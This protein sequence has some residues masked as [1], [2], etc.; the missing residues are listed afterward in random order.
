MASQRVRQFLGRVGARLA[1]GEAYRSLFLEMRHD[2]EELAE[3]AYEFMADC[4]EDRSGWLS[5]LCGWL[6]LEDL[7]ELGETARAHLLARPDCQ[8]ASV[9]VEH[10]QL[11]R[12]QVEAAPVLH[13]TFPSEVLTAWERRN[14]LRVDHPT[15]IARKPD[16][17]AGVVGG[18]GTGPCSACGGISERLLGLPADI[19]PGGVITSRRSVEFIWCSNCSMFAQEATFAVVDEAGV[20]RMLPM[21]LSLE[22]GLPPVA[23]AE[24]EMPVGFVDLGSEWRRQDWMW[25]NGVENLHRVGGTPTS[26]QHDSHPLCPRCASQTIFLAQIAVEDLAL[27]EGLAYLHWCDHCAISAVVFQ[28]S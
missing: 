15:W 3:L 22:P 6:P 23:E 18:A 20:A 21:D 5:A 17:T 12:P 2:A 8:T 13:L 19:V 27:G 24:P 1:N 28:Q 16:T 7:A 9:L 10:L 26:I 14:P 4:D 11:R 25:S